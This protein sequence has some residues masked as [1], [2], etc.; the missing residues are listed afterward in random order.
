LSKLFSSSF[1]CIGS[2]GQG[3]LSLIGLKELN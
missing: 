2:D 3:S 1:Q